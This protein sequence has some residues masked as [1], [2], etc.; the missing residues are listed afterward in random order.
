VTV[1]FPPQPAGVAWPTD[2]WEEAAPVDGV[3]TGR[4][5]AAV[6]RLLA[7]PPELG[8]TLALAVVHGGRLVA[9]G[10][11]DG[12]DR[13]TA[14]ISWSTAKSITHAVVGL[15]V[16]DGALRVDD[17]VGAPEWQ[18]DGDARARITLQQL[19]EM[20]SGLRFNEEYVDVGVS[21]VVDMLFFAGKDDVAAYAASLP[22]DH[23]PGTVWSYSSGTT[24]IVSRRCG[25]AVGGG[26][27][28]TR[29]FLHERLFGPLGMRSAEPSFD[30]AGTFIGSSF[31][32]ATARDFARFGLLYL[33]DGVW[34]DRRLLP[35]GWAE[36]ARTP[37]PG[38]PAEE[39]FGY[40]A[41]WW[42]WR[43]VP[44]MFGAH[45]YEGQY[46]LVVPDRDLVVVRL[47][48]TDADLRPNLVAALS[49]IVASFP[50]P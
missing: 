32:H 47:G 27:E 11:A 38:V 15:L 35:A 21:H 4:L 25:G 34:G 10:Y 13:D 23:A 14:L 2:E 22:L 1:P 12:V 43:D 50:T 45:G 39:P 6:A 26:E 41:H 20:R 33:R 42:L 36:H 37:T 3:D 46:V 28:G 8:L 30:A 24:N 17:P 5:S 18:A 29:R 49:E 9:E 7:Q 40:G 44:G 19:L 48:K 31:V 16:G